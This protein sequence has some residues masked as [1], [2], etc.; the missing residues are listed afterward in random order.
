MDAKISH[1][2][3]LSNFLSEK[4]SVCNDF[5][6]LLDKFRLSQSLRKLRMEKQKGASSL[7]LLKYLLIFRLF[8]QT[9]HQ[10][11]RYQFAPFIDGGKNQFYRFLSR[12][13]MDWRK[14]LYRTVQSFF[15]IVNHESI[16]PEQERFFILDDTT[17]EKSDICHEEHVAA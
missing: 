17:L 9:I 7:D 16:D 3:E 15:R 8:S 6:S 13:R 2:S 11:L 12:P 5:L 4:S 1:F 10:S 14:L